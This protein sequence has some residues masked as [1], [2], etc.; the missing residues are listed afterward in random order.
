ML[1]CFMVNLP[2]VWSLLASWKENRLRKYL[3]SGQSL[4]LAHKQKFPFQIYMSSFQK[5]LLSILF[6]DIKEDW[7]K[8]NTDRKYA[9]AA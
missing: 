1:D 5:S 3:L 8:G 6:K 4:V 2:P 9:Q 7:K